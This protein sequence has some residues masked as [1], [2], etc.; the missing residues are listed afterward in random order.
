MHHIMNWMPA[1]SL[2]VTDKWRGNG[3][4]FS[5]MTGHHLFSSV[6]SSL[7]SQTWL[8]VRLWKSLT[9]FVSQ[10]APQHLGL[11]SKTRWWT[12]KEHSALLL[13]D[14]AWI[15]LMK[16]HKIE[17]IYNTLS[18]SHLMNAEQLLNVT[19]WWKYAINLIY[20]NLILIMFICT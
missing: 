19:T 11:K 3:L 9:T 6:T 16:I 2:N 18:F 20:L 13:K 5:S 8:R 1:Q 17:T 10:A 14:T 4:I 7:W 12:I 15:A